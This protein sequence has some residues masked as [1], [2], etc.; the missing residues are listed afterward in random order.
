MHA[1]NAQFEPFDTSYVPVGN[2]NGG[3]RQGSKFPGTESARKYKNSG[4]EAKKYLKTKDITFLDSANRAHFTR[5]FAQIERGNQQNSHILRK[6]ERKA[7]NREARLE[8]DK[9]SATWPAADLTARVPIA[10]GECAK[11]RAVR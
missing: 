6:T 9:K 10:A 3:M 5:K 8:S 11:R 1:L 2:W 7:S 4:N